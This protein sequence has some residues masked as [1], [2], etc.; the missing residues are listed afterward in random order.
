[1]AFPFPLLLYGGSPIDPTP[2]SLRQ[3]GSL[4]IQVLLGHGAF[5]FL[6]PSTQLSCDPWFTL[7]ALAICLA[8]SRPEVR[9][10]FFLS[11]CLAPTYTSACLVHARGQ[12]RHQCPKM[13]T[14]QVTLVPDVPLCPAHQLPPVTGGR[15]V[16]T[17]PIAEDDSAF[18]EAPSG[19]WLS[20][21]LL[22]WPPHFLLPP[23]ALTASKWFF[24]HL[25]RL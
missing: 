4:G 2:P 22:S 16:K 6:A 8:L 1:M 11:I 18:S 5:S 9:T 7:W 12:L 3:S 19:S 25:Q 10:G 21:V 20:V 13:P 14:G 17:L 15:W 24:S 23:P